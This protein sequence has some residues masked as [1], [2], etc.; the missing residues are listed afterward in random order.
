MGISCS[1]NGLYLR[2]YMFG[3]ALAANDLL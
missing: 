3:I 2:L 1:L